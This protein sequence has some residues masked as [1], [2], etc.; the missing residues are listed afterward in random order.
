MAMLT[1]AQ[2]AQA[3]AAGDAAA[4]EH[5][6]LSPRDR[7]ALRDMDGLPLVPSRAWCGYHVGVWCEAGL[8]A[9]DPE[10]SRFRM[11]DAGRA[12]VGGR[13]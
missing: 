7:T 5:I 9:I 13:L 10:C 6:P 12:L 8:L 11:T 2:A 3:F 4:S 1:P